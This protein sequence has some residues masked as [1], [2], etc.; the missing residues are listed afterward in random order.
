MQ[1]ENIIETLLAFGNLNGAKDIA[2]SSDIV[3]IRL[4]IENDD[5]L[6]FEACDLRP[7]LLLREMDRH[8]GWVGGH[9]LPCAII[10]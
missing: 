10:L 6:R 3:P 2:C 8:D 4:P 5:P 1:I 7:K 9:Y